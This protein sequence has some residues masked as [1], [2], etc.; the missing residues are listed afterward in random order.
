MADILIVDDD[1]DILS[2]LREILEVNGYSVESAVD[3]TGAIAM[4]KAAP[5]R[6]RTP[7]YQSP[8]HG[9]DRA[10]G[11]VRKSGRG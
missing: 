6:N 4:V 7:R 5:Y 2:T 3:G 9:G 10:P 8:G 11:R 1:P